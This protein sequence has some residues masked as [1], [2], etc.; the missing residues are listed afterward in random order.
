VEDR[1][2]VFHSVRIDWLG[3]TFNSVSVVGGP[4][5]ISV[6]W[7]GG[8]VEDELMGKIVGDVRFALKCIAEGREVSLGHLD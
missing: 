7:S 1:A 4:L 6:T 5:V 2:D 8:D 3:V